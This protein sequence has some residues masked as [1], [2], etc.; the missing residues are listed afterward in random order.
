MDDN[1]E[2]YYIDYLFWEDSTVYGI[3]CESVLVWV[4]QVH[5]R[6]KANIMNRYNQVVPHLI[7]DTISYVMG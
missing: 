7:Q 3:S 4:K 5:V 6:K 2:F 1:N